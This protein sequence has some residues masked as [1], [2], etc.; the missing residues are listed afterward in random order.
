MPLRITVTTMSNPQARFFQG[1]FSGLNIPADP[2]TLLQ[3]APESLTAML[4]NSGILTEQNAV[5]SIRHSQVVSG[6]STGRKLLIEPNYRQSSAQLPD[7]LFIKF[8]RDFDEP[9]RDQARHQLGPEVRLGRLSNHPGFPIRVPSCYF[10][11]FQSGDGSGILVSET[12]QFGEGDILPLFEKCQD[13]DIANVDEFYQCIVEAQA[14][15]AA[16][17]YRQNIATDIDRYFPF[18]AKRQ[19]IAQ[20]QRYPLEKIQKRLER[21]L[22][23]M[24]QYPGLFAA[25]L[26]PQKLQ[27]SLNRLAPQVLEKLPKLQSELL[28]DPD[29]IALMHW[30]ANIDNAWFWRNGGQLHCGLFDWGGVDQM[31]I[32]QALWGAFSAAE[33]RLLSEKLRLLLEQF[34]STLEENGGPDL[35]PETLF[36]HTATSSTILSFSWLLDAPALIVRSAGELPADVDRF[37]PAIRESETARTQLQMLNNFLWLWQEKAA[38]IVAA[39]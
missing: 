27:A 18:Q 8:S 36:A 29:Y 19:A 32:G 21:L 24:Q 11:D 34:S 15:L 31:N 6:G 7:Q 33:T 23:F 2:A 3:S 10:G 39:A 9:I 4:R 14:K 26:D 22:E 25:H 35:S 28:S 37:Y 38:D 20:P 1:D 30:N 16:C 5:E 12:V 13:E 17:N